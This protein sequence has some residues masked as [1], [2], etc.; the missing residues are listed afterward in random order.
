MRKRILSMLLALLMLFSAIPA[1]VFAVGEEGETPV[2][3]TLPPEDL[4][5]PEDQSPVEETP[6]APVLC[7]ICGA[8]DCLQDHSTGKHQSLMMSP[9]PVNTLSDA[10]D[11]SAD[12]GKYVKLNPAVT[13]FSVYNQ[14]TG[15]TFT[16]Y[17][18]D[19]RSDSIFTITNWKE[20]A[21]GLWYQ[22]SFYRGGTQGDYVSDFPANPWFLQSGDALIF[23]TP[24]LCCESCAEAEGCQCLCG[25]CDFCQ[26]ETPE[27][28][29]ACCES[30]TGAEGCA[31]GCEGCDFCQ[32]EE[33]VEPE[34]PVLT[35]PTGVEVT[36]ESFPEGVTLEVAEVSGDALLGK[37]S[38]P[39][40]KAVFAL[41]I[42]LRNADATQYQPD[43]AMVK[44]PVNAPVGTNIGIIHD[45]N[46]D[47]SFMGVTQVLADGTVEFVTENFSTFAGF[48]VDF[49]YNGST[50]SIE[51]YDSILLSELF[52][53]F[54][55]PEDATQATSVVFSDDSLVSVSKDGNN[56]RLTSLDAFQTEETLIITFGDGHTIVIRV[57]D[58]VGGKEDMGDGSSQK[59]YRFYLLE[60][61]PDWKYSDKGILVWYNNDTAAEWLSGYKIKFTMTFPDGSYKEDTGENFFNTTALFV[62]LRSQNGKYWFKLDSYS[63]VEISDGGTEYISYQIR[64]KIT[65]K[66]RTVNFTARSTAISL[67]NAEY[68]CT[69]NIEPK[70]SMSEENRTVEVWLNGSKIDSK[71]VAF[72][73]R[74]SSLHN[75]IQYTDESKTGSADIRVSF[76]NTGTYRY[77]GITVNQ[78]TKTYRLDFYNYTYQL[79]YNVNGGSGTIASTSVGP[80]AATSGAVPVTSAEPTRN[81]YKFLGWAESASATSAQYTAGG[82]VTINAG[83]SSS[84]GNPYVTSKTVYAVWQSIPSV[85]IHHY[86]QGTTTKVADDTVVDLP[87]NQSVTVANY[88]KTIT[89]YEYVSCSPASFTVGDTAAANTATIYYKNVT[90]YKVTWVFG[91]G[92]G[93]KVDTVIYGGTI[94]KPSDPTRTGYTFNGWSPAVPATMPAS[95]QTFT[96]QWKKTGYSITYDLKEGG[97]LPAGKSN[98]NTYAV[99]SAAITL[100]NPEMSGYTFT[101]WT[102]S[103][104]PVNWISGFIEINTG[105]YQTYNSSYPNAHYSEKIYLEAGVTYTL[106]GYSG[107]VRW[108]YFDLNGNYLGNLS[109]TTTFTPEQN[110]YVNI[111]LYETTTAENRDSVRITSSQGNSVTIATGST[112]NRHYTANYTVA[113]YA[114][115]YQYTGTVPTGVGAVPG[116][117]TKLY[118]AA[119]TVAAAPTTVKGYT[120]SGWSTSDVTVGADGTFTMPAKAVTFTGSWIPKTYTINYHANGGS[121]S[122]D[123]QTVQFDGAIAIRNNGFTVP[124]GMRFAG[125]A[126]SAT[127]AAGEHGWSAANKTGWSGTW[128]FDNG[129]KGIANDTLNLYA[130]W[131]ADDF[132]LTGTIDNGGTVTYGQQ[133]LKGGQ[134]S[135]T[136]VFTPATGYKITGIKINGVDQTVTNADTYTFPARTVTEDWEVDVTTDIKTFTVQWLNGTTVLQSG[137]VSYGDSVTYT[138]ETPVS[139][140]A[141]YTVTFATWKLE[142]GVPLS[143]DTVSNVTQ[144]LVISAWFNETLVNYTITYDLA[145]GTLPAGVTSNQQSYNV[146][147]SAALMDA[148]TKAGYEFTGWKLE[149]GLDAPNGNWAADNYEAGQVIP[150]GK[151]GNVTLVA[152]Y[153]VLD[154]TITFNWNDGTNRSE[155]RTVTFGTTNNNDVSALA[156][157]RTGYIFTGWFTAQDGGVQV[158]DKEGKCITSKNAYWNHTDKL[159]WDDD[160]KWNHDGDLTL[161]AHWTANTYEIH[162]SG[163]GATGGSMDALNVAYDASVQLPVNAFTRVIQVTYDVNGGKALAAD[164][165]QVT[166]TADFTGW[167]H[168]N[169]DYADQATVKNLASAQGAEVTLVA[170]W[171]LKSTVA[172]TPERDGY[173]FT[174]WKVDDSTTYGA[175][176]TFTPTQNTTLVAQWDAVEYTITYNHNNDLT[177]P[178]KET[179]TYKITDD[180]TL[181][182]APTRE[183][184]KFTGW[185]LKEKLF[186]P[187]GNWEDNSGHEQGWY[188]ASQN[189]GTGKYGNITLVAQWQDLYRY[190]V[191]YNANTTD[192]VDGM[193]AAVDTGWVEADKYN[194]ALPTTP[195]RA[196][197]DFLGWATSPDA[198][199]VLTTYELQGIGH[200]AKDVTLYAVWQR[201]T[202]SLKLTYNGSE[203]APAIVTVTGQGKTITLVLTKSETVITGLPTGQYTVTAESGNA[204]Y[205]ATVKTD[206]AP[207]VEANKTAVVEI[208]TGTRGLNW[209]TAFFRVKNKCS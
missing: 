105:E 184:Y 140:K 198:A 104:D 101:G 130:I 53:I 199:D 102:E 74:D 31:C 4:S 30:C 150:L 124:A 41:D 61:G 11:Y 152:Q 149:T 78:S 6:Q 122:M 37:F 89:N 35:H 108:R 97:A 69:V 88:K 195:T 15:N 64:P 145:G 120:F 125:W 180:L 126:V 68:L 110:G 75:H 182:A 95:D 19:F 178:T 18:E 179:A 183:G 170:R 165:Q 176:E 132:T 51:G 49:H 77:G 201:Q 42:S 38:V 167:K 45:H 196:D 144:D 116:Q 48:T 62:K 43:G 55:I 80:I 207:T 142:N 8:A 103:I 84:N 192:T 161:Y 148:P 50:Y 93:N 29:C 131:E 25:H 163:N 141:G 63:N 26:P 208:T 87:Y 143:G 186:V 168:G 16:Y 66:T 193:P 159:Y 46:G 171:D 113:Q 172:P 92:T 187:N 111:L 65:T 156:P 32:P 34:L 76:K 36:A 119:G 73:V 205:T 3:E 1:N 28:P 44:V 200:T 13:T 135:Q 138:G 58:E 33:P 71:T 5:Q 157:I 23:V 39:A 188:T 100:N 137:E 169:T 164:K 153:R 202:G 158:Y 194:V 204:S 12:V 70:T 67:P 27:N 127:G 123:S 57:T 10:P 99:D 154:R 134:T 177:N 79:N 9:A 7:E 174:G 98:P 139:D 173:T 107:G 166:L 21:S 191:T 136:M 109:T 151:Y 117:T 94:T 147:V 118:G 83:G 90:K 128:T 106:T 22:L 81:G 86:L 91:N 129:E 56:W 47:I 20:D 146:T 162:F 206:P 24:C 59:T 160:G 112:G 181:A 72:P 114:V 190:Q 121:G 133:N 2:V 189:I 82:T 40:A 17:A 155:S 175:D 14:D 54:E 203:T 115:T 209:F 60:S 85:T 52:E 96:A 185:K 197:Y